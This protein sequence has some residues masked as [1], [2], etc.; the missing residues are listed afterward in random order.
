MKH[1]RALSE[2]EITS[3]QENNCH[4]SDWNLVK[5]DPQ[6]NVDR[7]YN[8]SFSGEVYLGNFENTIQINGE[9][10]RKSGIY[11]SSIHNC[12]ISDNVYINNVL[13]QIANYF[14]D[15]LAIIENVDTLIVSDYSTFGNGVDVNVLN[16]SGGREVS[17]YNE[18]SSHTA[19]LLTFYRHRPKFIENVKKFIQKYSDDIKS[20]VGYI[21]RGSYLSNSKEIRDVVIGEYATVNGALKLFNGTINS[22]E[23]APT[24]IGYGVIAENFI[25]QEGASVTDGS[26][27]TNSLIGQ[28]AKIGKQYS[29]DNSLFFAN[30]QGFH[31]EACSIFAGPFTATHHKST[32][33]I[34]GYYS[35]FNAGS[36]SNQSNHLYKL[37]PV[38]Q[39]VVERGSKTASDSYILWP[40]KIGAFSL[41]IG[42][43]YNNPDTSFFPYSYIVEENSETFLI[44]GISL[45]SVGTI[46]DARKW[47]QR[48]NRKFV[49]VYDKITYNLL[50]PYSIQKMV[51]GLSLLNESVK[52]NRDLVFDGFSIKKSGVER[53]IKLY[54][55][56][57]DKFL[58]NGLVKKIETSQFRNISELRTIL[59]PRITVDSEE[60]WID[61]AGLI[62][63]Q[64]IVYDLIDDVENGLNP[65]F[66]NTFSEWHENYLDMVWS[67]SIDKL[68]ELYKIDIFKTDVSELVSLVMRW[69][70]AVVELDMMIY[71]DAKKEFALKS[72]VG[73]GID[74]DVEEKLLDFSNVR[75][76]FEKHPDVITIVEHIAQKKKTANMAI[77]KLKGIS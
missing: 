14:V 75:G 62:V 74:G 77:E 48:D 61:I 70:K 46:R 45:R 11:N 3:L 16:E 63:P 56:A 23:E 28:G 18:L 64:T 21:G 37:G 1:Y 57:L 22:S 35:F 15:E 71:E 68:R 44:P 39:G 19:Y 17:I 12:V 49:D 53:G 26:I 31:G 54:E 34:A 73:F 55:L 41:V 43:H 6:F 4:C 66:D 42:K 9:K 38:H 76:E 5:V 58:L 33:L 13:V 52:N 72:K 10:P 69:E 24:E 60:L 36:G 27:V 51:K 59:A 7:V 8:V 50:N 65:E 67:W 32:L 29:V 40:A 25:L 20:N 47:A 2:L 30:S